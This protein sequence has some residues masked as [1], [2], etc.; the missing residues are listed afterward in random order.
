[1]ATV[2]FT[3]EDIKAYLDRN[4]LF[5]RAKRE[6]RNKMASYYINAY[7][8]VRMSLFDELLSED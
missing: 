4:I 8:S 5:W 3:K 2:K 1:M 7:Q 6:K